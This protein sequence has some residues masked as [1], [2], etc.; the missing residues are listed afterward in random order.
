VTSPGRTRHHTSPPQRLSMSLGEVVAII[1]SL[2][3][4]GKHA[5][6]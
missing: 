5:Q 4:R 2:P 1:V 3:M 6:P